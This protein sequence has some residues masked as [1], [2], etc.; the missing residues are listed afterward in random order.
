MMDTLITIRTLG[1]DK[2]QVYAQVIGKFAIHPTIGYDNGTYTV[3][4]VALGQSI[5]NEL[6][7]QEEAEELARKLDA[8]VVEDIT[9]NRVYTEEYKAFAKA[10]RSVIGAARLEAMEGAN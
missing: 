10:V 2:Q 4:H 5:T 8:A 3:T 9:P 6:K 1:G 7:S